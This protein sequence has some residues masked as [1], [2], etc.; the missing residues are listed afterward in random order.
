MSEVINA[1]SLKTLR[2]VTQCEAAC[3]KTERIDPDYLVVFGV[4][5]LKGAFR[6]LS[7]GLD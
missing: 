7:E 1:S 4:V 6:R 5:L 3:D 2:S